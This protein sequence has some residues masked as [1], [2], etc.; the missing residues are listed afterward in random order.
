MPGHRF[1][2]AN[3]NLLGLIAEDHL[4]RFGFGN[5]AES[6][7]SGVRVNVIDIA[8]RN[9]R[10]VEGGSHRRRGS[11]AIFWRRSHVMRVSGESIACDLAINFRPAL[12][13]VLELFDHANSRAFAH[14]E[15][16]PVAIE[17]T[18]S[19]LRLIVA[20]AQGPHR[21]KSGETEFDDRRFGAA[22]Q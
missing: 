12:L 3:R 15:S 9:L 22:S 16:V 17:W 18:R 11:F 20:P 2:R 14:D 6:S 5:I 7:R 4:D 21:R 13:R 1:G 19:A 8:R 10:V